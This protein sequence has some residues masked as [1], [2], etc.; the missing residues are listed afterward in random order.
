LR[1]KWG[2]VEPSRAKFTSVGTALSL[3]LS[4]IKGFIPMDIV[5]LVITSIV[6]VMFATSFLLVPL[7][8]STAG[9]A[10]W[11][12]KYTSMVYFSC[13]GLGFIVLELVFIQVFMKL[14]GFP[15]YTYS[16]VIFAL[17]CSAGVG[18]LSAAR[19]GITPNRRWTWPFAGILVTGVLLA[20][21]YSYIFGY[22]L[23]SP[24]GVRVAVAVCCV[25]PVGFFLGMPLPLGILALEKQ[26]PGAIA[27]AWGLNALFTVVGG[28]ISVILSIF[29]GFAAALFIALAV[30]LLAFAV[31]ARLR[32][33]TVV[34]EETIG[35]PTT[36]FGVAVTTR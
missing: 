4:V 36:T 30:Y 11:E 33:A 22:F 32:K 1:K 27:W 34:A 3:N 6:S 21:S 28:L 25:L 35:D 17:L 24:F 8:F 26:P 23:A 16:V 5:H 29:V 10:R 18:S 2:D 9:T 31:F 19:L 15:V 14:V 7:Y 13:L 12:H 20:L